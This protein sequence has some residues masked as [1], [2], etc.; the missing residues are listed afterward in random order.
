MIEFAEHRVLCHQ[1]AAERRKRGLNSWAYRV[2]L[3]RILERDDDDDEELT[4]EQYAQ[5]CQD[6]AKAMKSALPAQ[7]FDLH[8][9]DADISFIDLIDNFEQATA[10]SFV[11][12]RKNGYPPHEMVNGWLSELYDWCDINRVWTGG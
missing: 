1:L 9:E 2:N 4:D 6:I 12:D 5:R 11:G 10:A 8:H 7:F 3:K